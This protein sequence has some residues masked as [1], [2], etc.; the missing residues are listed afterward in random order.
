MERCSLCGNEGAE[1]H[2]IPQRNYANA[3]PDELPKVC[4]RCADVIRDRTRNMARGRPLLRAGE[5]TTWS[6]GS[7]SGFEDRN[8]VR[9]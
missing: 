6:D 7:Q 8:M 3:K 4:D 2:V 9:L 1:R 5:T